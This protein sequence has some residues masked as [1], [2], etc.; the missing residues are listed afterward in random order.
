VCARRRN[1]SDIPWYR[2]GPGRCAPSCST[3]TS[4]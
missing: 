2:P 4:C 1:H 3:R